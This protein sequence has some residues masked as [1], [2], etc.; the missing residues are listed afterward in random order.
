MS[1]S[2]EEDVKV[3][4]TPALVR[5]LLSCGATSGTYFM[6]AKSLSS[7]S[8][9]LTFLNGRASKRAFV[10]A[11]ALLLGEIWFLVSVALVGGVVMGWWLV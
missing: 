9:R 3:V 7:S 8:V 11:S 2:F 1:L 6:H 5:A 10:S 4:L